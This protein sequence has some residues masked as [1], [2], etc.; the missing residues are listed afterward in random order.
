VAYLMYFRLIERIGPAR[1]ITVTFVI[2]VFG[3]VYGAA[4]LGERI[5]LT[6]LV[7]GAI[8]VLGTALSTGVLQPRSGHRKP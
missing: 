4:L 7:C 1:A 2:P 8:I 6:M 5:T 3:V